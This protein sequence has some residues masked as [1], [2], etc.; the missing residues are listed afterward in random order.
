MLL[1]DNARP[2]WKSARMRWPGGAPDCPP[3]VSE[4]RW[5]DLLF[6]DAKCDMQ[7]CVSENVLVNFTLRRRVCEACYKKHLV[8][9]QK[10]KRTFPD[11]DKSMLELIP[12]G[13]AGCRSRFWRRKKLQ[14]YWAG[15]IHNMAKQVASYREAIESG[16]AGAEDAFLSFKSARIAHVEYVVEHAQVCLDWLEDQEYLRREQVRLR[17]EA[18]R[19]EIFGRFE[20][21]GYERQD[22]NYLDSDVLS[23][24]AELTEDDWDGIRATL[25]PTIIYYRTNRLKR[26]RNALLTRRRRVVDQVCTAVKKTLPP[27]Q[28]NAF[29]P[30][31]ELYDWEGFSVLIN[32]PSQSELEPQGC[33][34]V[35]EA[36]PSFI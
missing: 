17:I 26:E 24:D 16:K 29:P 15:D 9:D 31:H 22:F 25:E 6:G 27:L 23:I 33:A 13:N 35:L 14:F 5:A 7:S 11:Y 12:S 36:L 8:F 30:F 10:F 3:D 34:R 2:I 20:E 28:W 21:L 18:R 32:D 4:A 1:A 19:N